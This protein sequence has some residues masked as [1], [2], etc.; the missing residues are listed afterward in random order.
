MEEKQAPV[1]ARAFVPKG[2]DIILG[3]NLPFLKQAPRKREIFFNPGLH[4]HCSPPPLLLKRARFHLEWGFISNIHRPVNQQLLQARVDE[5]GHEG[6]IVSTHR[7]NAFTVHL[8]MGV[9]VGREV[10]AGI[11]LLIDQEVG[12]V[13]LARR[14]V[15]GNSKDPMCESMKGKTS[16]KSFTE[17]WKKHES[18]AL[19][20]P[21]Y[22]R[23]R[24]AARNKENSQHFAKKVTSL[25]G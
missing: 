22:R 16:F 13:H 8:V 5:V 25:H 21:R 24:L 2:V 23:T 1:E 7:L 19:K 11:A 9:R 3:C 10:Q 4:M 18:F 6:A 20:K 12:E 17:S 14:Q 15:W